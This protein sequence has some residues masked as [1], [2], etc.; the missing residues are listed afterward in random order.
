M[1]LRTRSTSSRLSHLRDYDT[2]ELLV[3]G[4]TCPHQQGH[5]CIYV[6]AHIYAK[7]CCFI[8]TQVSVP[9]FVMHIVEVKQCRM[10]APLT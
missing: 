6:Y 4:H 1:Q 8:Y 7:I 10:S 2:M 3:L 5:M 9:A